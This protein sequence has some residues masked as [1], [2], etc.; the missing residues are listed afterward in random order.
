MTKKDCK[1]VTVLSSLQLL[2]NFL[3]NAASILRH[4]IQALHISTFLE[5]GCSEL[6]IYLLQ[7][8]NGPLCKGIFLDLYVL[9]EIEY[10]RPW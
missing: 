10:I 5:L 8:T 9:E 7:N 4:S 1:A 3:K 6:K 2:F